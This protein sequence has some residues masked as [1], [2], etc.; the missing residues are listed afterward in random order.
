MW[1]NYLTIRILL[2]FLLTYITSSG[3]KSQCP[4]IDISV[5]VSCK[6][7]P[8]NLVNNSSPTNF[9]TWDFCSGDFLNSPGLSSLGVFEDAINS[10]RPEIVYDS[11]SGTFFGFIAGQS[12]L[13]RFKVT[14]SLDSIFDLELLGNFSGRINRPNGLSIISWNGMWFGFYVNIN[15]SKG[16]H[17]M[18]FG[19]TLAN[20][21]LIED[22]GNFNSIGLSRGIDIVK[23]NDT[24]YVIVSNL[25]QQKLTLVNFENDPA[26]T[27]DP[28]TNVKE[29]PIPDSNIQGIKFAADCN[30]WYGFV[31]TRGDNSL[32][33]LEFF[34][35]LWNDPV[36]TNLTSSIGIGDNILTDIDITVD[37]NNRLA[38]L[39]TSIK[40]IFSLNFGDD[41]LNMPEVRELGSISN[42]IQNSYG[43]KIIRSNSISKCLLINYNEKELVSINFPQN[44][45]APLASYKGFQPA[46][47][48][49][50]EPGTYPI[51]I[52]AYDSNGNVYYLPDSINIINSPDIRFATDLKCNSENT[53]FSD[54][55]SSSNGEIVFWKWN[56]YD[57]DSSFQRS[58]KYQFTDAGDYDVNLRVVD[59]AGCSS[60]STF[61]IH[62]YDSTDLSPDFQFPLT[63]CSH[64]ETNFSD[65]SLFT[66]DS[67]TYWLWDFGDPMS[68]ENNISQNQNAS[69]IYKESG[70]FNVSLTI[71]GI[72][73]CSRSKIN[74][75]GPIQ[76]I[77]GPEVDYTWAGS[78]EK[79]VYSF[80]NQT[81]GGDFVYTWD[82]GD[83]DTSSLKNPIHLYPEAGDYSV[84]LT[85]ASDNGCLNLKRDT[86]A[87]HHLPVADF[88]SELPCSRSGITFYDESTVIEA[89]IASWEWTYHL[90]SD[91]S[92]H[93]EDSIRNPVILFN[94]AADYEVY[95]TVSSNYG[96]LD[97]IR[98]TIE[99]LPSPVA[100]FSQSRACL[101]DTTYFRD[102]SSIPGENI[103]NHWTWQIENK[104][105]TGPSPSHPFTGEG[106]FDVILTVQAE[107]LCRD[108]IELPVVIHPLPQAALR[109]ENN[110][111]NETIR[112]YS[113][114]ISISDPI[115][116]YLWNIEG[117]GSRTGESVELDFGQPGNY[118]IS[119]LVITENG[120]QDTLLQP[121]PVYEAPIAA[122]DY[123]PKYGAF[124]FEVRFV[125]LSSGATIYTWDFDEG[126]VTSGSINPIYTYDT[127]GA[128]YPSLVVTNQRGC[129][130]STSTLIFV[131]DPELEVSL[132]EVQ[133]IQSNGRINFV[134]DIKNTGT[135]PIDNMDILIRVNGNFSVRETFVGTLFAGDQIRYPLNFE[136]VDLPGQHPEFICFE[137]HPRNPDYEEGNPDDN[138][139][140]LTISSPT[141]LLEP[142]PNPTYGPL[143]VDLILPD[144][145]EVILQLI[146]LD[147]KILYTRS[148]QDT[149]EGLNTF[150]ME[151]SETGQGIYV[152]RVVYA[153][154]FISKRIEV[155]R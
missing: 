68:D 118:Q 135:I 63:G 85:A 71:T 96:C 34:E 132:L 114:A 153:D 45:S 126:G 123:S 86:V 155:I 137:L 52:E 138:R 7:A 98:K 151:L 32:F 46:G 10:E 103:I 16:L 92:N 72:S 127:R 110:C 128:H 60:D 20:M 139:D 111:Q 142:Y 82:F 5:D 23:D 88:V 134:T 30:R 53:I 143:S 37:Q 4:E 119:H 62:I 22:L 55:S 44:C 112:L 74:P 58:T 91:P 39:T 130:D 115:T 9:F 97:S 147:G 15:G 150:R 101:G 13:Y 50:T 36:I 49:Y 124:P 57:M 73:G 120:C 87:V 140:C 90:T 61:L 152:L 40:K 56:F 104:I 94:E 125:N 136:L 51:Q 6:N 131:A 105:Y 47:I 41:F 35:S 108:R 81:A 116:Q 24:L 67:I 48:Y 99:I 83:G 121:L 141:C 100:S 12:Q 122:F 107:N 18:S 80:D 113:E 148:I 54:S 79:D 17:R 43:I 76:I 1:I 25:N 145:Q 64:S 75:L 93:G 102:E 11:L 29:I 106:A 117:A 70:I 33:R 109:V 89:N 77:E 95:L 149:R 133:E 2:L 146:S 66:E 31:T 65:Q 14:N 38:F 19:N 84:T 78:C 27:P 154:L 59:S 42:S 26:F 69:H 28:T 21:P 3:L 129:Q 144:Q 8:I